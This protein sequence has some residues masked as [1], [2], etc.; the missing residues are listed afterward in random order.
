M[1]VAGEGEYAGRGED[2]ERVRTLTG[3]VKPDWYI[4]GETVAGGYEGFDSAE[5][6]RL[7]CRGY[8]AGRY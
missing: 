6:E 4:P 3:G 7:W 2:T 1:E 5:P 8:A